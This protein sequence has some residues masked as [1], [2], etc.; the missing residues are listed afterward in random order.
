L[1]SKAA[2]SYPVLFQSGEYRVY[3]IA[4]G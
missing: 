4:G 3:R 1:V 2:Y